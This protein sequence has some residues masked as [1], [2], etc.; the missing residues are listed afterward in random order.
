[1]V[2]A[3]P[4][5]IVGRRAGVLSPLVWQPVLAALA[6]VAFYV[7]LYGQLPYCDVIRF[8]AQIDSGKF[9]LNMG[10]V[11]LQP[12]TLLWH[13]YLGFGE[14]AEHS[15]KHI[16]TAFAAA[17]IGVFYFALPTPHVVLDQLYESSKDA[18]VFFAAVQAKVDPVLVRGG[19][20][21]VF[22]ALDPTNWNAPWMLLTRDGMPK[23]KF[24]GFFDSHYKA[25]PK[26]EIA[27]ME[28]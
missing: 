16:N 26:G 7:S 24:T 4:T 21:A 23:A 14:T 19:R 1:M 10:H 13:W 17:G 11:W 15:Q 12:V 5:Q 6:A 20:V 8:I 2:S 22:E 3:A 27:G 25:V 18:P 28:A 9:V